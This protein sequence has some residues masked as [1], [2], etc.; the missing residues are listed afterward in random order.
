MYDNIATINLPYNQQKLTAY[1]QVFPLSTISAI[2][3]KV[4]QGQK[5]V[6]QPE[7]MKCKMSAWKITQ[8]MIERVVKLVQLGMSD[9]QPKRPVDQEVG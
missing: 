9:K 4:M 6:K 5:Q 3:P 8:D 2:R 1:L 7:K